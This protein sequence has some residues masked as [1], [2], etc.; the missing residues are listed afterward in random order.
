MSLSTPRRLRVHEFAK[1]L[2][3][4]PRLMLAAA[5]AASITPSDLAKAAPPPSAPV[6][7]AII[8]EQGLNVLHDDFRARTGAQATRGGMPRTATVTLPQTG[9]FTSR[10]RA[11]QRGPL[12]RMRPGTLYGIKG[13]RLVGLI[14][15]DDPAIQGLDASG[16]YDLFQ[17]VEHGTGVASAAVGTRYGTAPD[18]LL[19]FVVSPVR[20]GW[21]WATRQPWIDIISTSYIGSTPVVDSGSGAIACPEGRAVREFTDSGRLVFAANGNG[22][23]AAQALSPP[24]LPD[25]F[26]VGGVNPDGG[27]VT[28]EAV[29]RGAVT[30]RLTPNRPYETGELFDFPAASPFALTGSAGFGGTSGAAPRTAGHAARLISHARARLGNAPRRQGELASAR[31]GVQAPR[32]GPL[33]DGTL[34]GNELARVLRHTATPRLDDPRSRYAVEGYGAFLTANVSLAMRVL[35]GTIPE[36]GRPDEDTADAAVRQAR[37]LQFPAERCR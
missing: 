36:P 20:A 11:A 22:A 1:R 23:D 34:T 33:A 32:T 31:K 17:D 16:D 9:D 19:V 5:L 35:S 30:G 29:T 3:V 12:G 8:G 15:P 37:A 24:A 27:T 10:L 14:V 13:T 28:T 21:E 26:H 25:V 4:T 18:A 6:V 2:R 7:I